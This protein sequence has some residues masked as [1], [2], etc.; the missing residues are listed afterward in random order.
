MNLG[1]ILTPSIQKEIFIANGNIFLN[2]NDAPDGIVF[3]QEFAEIDKS[4]SWDVLRSPYGLRGDMPPDEA[5]GA[6]EDINSTYEELFNYKSSIAS[7]IGSRYL[8]ISVGELP[9]FVHG[10]QLNNIHLARPTMATQQ[11]MGTLPLV[12]LS[13]LILPVSLSVISV[14][15]IVLRENCIH[16]VYITNAKTPFGSLA[17]NKYWLGKEMVIYLSKVADVEVLRKI[18]IGSAWSKGNNHYFFKKAISRMN[19]LGEGLDTK[20][21]NTIIN[22]I[23]KLERNG[24]AHPY[25]VLIKNQLTLKNIKLA[26]DLI[27]DGIRVTKLSFS[28]IWFEE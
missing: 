16:E 21:R 7:Q 3:I 4:L 5:V 9:S 14:E 19:S 17:E 27:S 18:E 24:S 23:L 15:S 26:N 2:K 12:K 13:D 20:F 8:S 10:H 28:E 11:C 22:T 1:I 25:S 6:L